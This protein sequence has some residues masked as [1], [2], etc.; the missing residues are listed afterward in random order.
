MPSWVLCVSKSNILFCH[1][2]IH[3]QWITSWDLEETFGFFHQ[4][5]T[6]F[7]LGLFMLGLCWDFLQYLTHEKGYSQ[8]SHREYNSELWCPEVMTISWVKNGPT[9][10]VGSNKTLWVGTINITY[11]NPWESRDTENI[12]NFLGHRI[13]SRTTETWI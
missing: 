2:F 13:V 10:K 9:Y 7:L 1:C 4:H 8:G 6:N 12:I 11:Y 3:L 5:D